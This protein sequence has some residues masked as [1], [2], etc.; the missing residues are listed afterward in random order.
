M[1]FIGKF[2]KHVNY[3]YMHLDTRYIYTHTPPPHTHT[4]FRGIFSDISKHQAPPPPPPGR[5]EAPENF[6]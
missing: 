1:R 4:L 3:K 6:A 2:F 5:R